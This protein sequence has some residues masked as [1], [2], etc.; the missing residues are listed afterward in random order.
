MLERIASQGVTPVLVL[1]LEASI[2]EESLP[3]GLFQR[4]LLMGTALG[5]KGVGL[6][7]T[8]PK[9][10]RALIELRATVGVNF[11]I[12]VDGGIRLET[13]PLL[14]AAGADGIVPGSLVFKA[15]DPISVLTW[16]HSLPDSMICSG[17]VPIAE[18]KVIAA[19]IS[20]VDHGAKIALPREKAGRDLK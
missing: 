15:P 7:S 16:L 2:S 12:F 10:I 13:A 6:D 18:G 5:V 14:A 20:F 4:V 3:W 9:R 1:P 11:E 17:D 19:P 8:V